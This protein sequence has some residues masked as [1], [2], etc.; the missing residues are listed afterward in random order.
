MMTTIVD[1]WPST[2]PLTDAGVILEGMTIVVLW[3]TPTPS[4]TL[5]LQLQPDPYCTH[6]LSDCAL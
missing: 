6:S 3:P 2:A 5:H 1:L 4:H